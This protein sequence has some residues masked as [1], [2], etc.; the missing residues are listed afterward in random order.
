MDLFRS[1]GEGRVAHALLDPLDRAN[2]NHWTTH[3]Q[4]QIYRTIDGQS[5]SLF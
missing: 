4:T 3:V 1:P 2:L 5:A